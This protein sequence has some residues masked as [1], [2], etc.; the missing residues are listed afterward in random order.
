MSLALGGQQG[1]EKARRAEGWNFMMRRLKYFVPIPRLFEDT[2]GM[3]D[4]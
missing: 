1:N 4:T 3:L 2:T